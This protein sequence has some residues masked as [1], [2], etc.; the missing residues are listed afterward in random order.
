MSFKHTPISE[1]KVYSID[2]EGEHEI[3]NVSVCE[4]ERRGFPNEYRVYS[5]IAQFEFCESEKYDI[6]AVVLVTQKG[7]TKVKGKGSKSYSKEII[8]STEMYIKEQIK[9]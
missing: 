6:D 9:A 7:K 2:F 1:E 3:R 5:V 4:V 8:K